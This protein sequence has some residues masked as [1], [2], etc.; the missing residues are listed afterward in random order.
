MEKQRVTSQLTMDESDKAAHGG[1]ALIGNAD[2]HLKTWP[3]IH[4]DC[5]RARPGLRSVVNDPYIPD[6]IAPLR[7][8]RTRRF[9]LFPDHELS[10]LAAKALLPERLLRKEAERESGELG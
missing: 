3:L 8:S 10:H 5:P 6:E 9:D 2:M 7:I 1:S 4:P